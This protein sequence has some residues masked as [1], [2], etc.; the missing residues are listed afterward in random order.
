[1]FGYLFGFFTIVIHLFEVG[2]LFSKKHDG[3]KKTLIR[4]AA[5]EVM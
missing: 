2:S 5:P 4:G 3:M 1:M